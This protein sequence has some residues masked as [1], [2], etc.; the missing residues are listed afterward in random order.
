MCHCAPVFTVL[1]AAAPAASRS[2][3]I[4][5]AAPTLKTGADLFANDTNVSE[6]VSFSPRICRKSHDS[7]VSRESE[8]ELVLLKEILA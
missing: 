6:F 2:R 4:R 8:R 3:R 5:E 7:C 1:W